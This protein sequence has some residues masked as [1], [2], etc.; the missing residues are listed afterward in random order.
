MRTFRVEILNP[1]AAKLLKN[2]ADL[3]LI[4]IDEIPDS[5]F[6]KVLARFRVKGQKPS[7]KDITKEA[8]IVRTQ[9]YER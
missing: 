3:N 7:F 2:L 1:K 6:A 8:E 9:R 4:I 5:G